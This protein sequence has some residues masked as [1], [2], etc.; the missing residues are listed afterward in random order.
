MIPFYDLHSTVP[1][2]TVPSF[3]KCHTLVRSCLSGCK[4]AIRLAVI[5]S[6]ELP[7]LASG[8]LVCGGHAGASSPLSHPLPSPFT[9]W[10][11]RAKSKTLLPPPTVAIALLLSRAG[12]GIS[13]C[14]CWALLLLAVTC[15]A[16]SWPRGSHL[17]PC[18]SNFLHA[19]P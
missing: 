10:S 5:A 16:K 19:G 8:R 15:L 11:H 3:L 14:L 4:Q 18:V 1:K 2:I 6:Q 13:A 12:T 9:G 17:Q 7:G